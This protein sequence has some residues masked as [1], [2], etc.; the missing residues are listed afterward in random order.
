MENLRFSLRDFQEN[1][2]SKFELNTSSSRKS[3]K[4]VSIISAQFIRHFHL[5]LTLVISS[6]NKNNR[7]LLDASPK[8]RREG[9]VGGGGVG[10]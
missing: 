1:D 4:R 3:S 9:E 2:I 10:W 8:C 6:T 7:L 5:V